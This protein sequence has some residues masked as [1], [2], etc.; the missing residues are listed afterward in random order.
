MSWLELIAG[1]QLN[2]IDWAYQIFVNEIYKIHFYML[3]TNAREICT[4]EIWESK[5]RSFPEMLYEI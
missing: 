4:S 5:Q 1:F 3:Y 2:L